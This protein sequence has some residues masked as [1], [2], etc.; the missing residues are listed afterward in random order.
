MVVGTWYGMNF[1]H[2][3]ELQS[4]HGYRNAILVTVIFTLITALYL[5][6]RKWF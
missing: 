1:D 2:M 5:K 4:A 3:R 6:K